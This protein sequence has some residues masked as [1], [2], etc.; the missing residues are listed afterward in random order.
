[1]SQ[2]G[3]IE[4]HGVSFKYRDGAKLF[5]SKSLKIHG[6]EK[7][8]L[9]GFS[10]SGKTTFAHLIMGLY[11]V[12]EG[13]ISIDGQNISEVSMSSLRRNISFI[14]QEPLLFHRSIMENIR[15][16]K[17]EATDEE[18]IDAAIKAHAHDFIIHMPNGYDQQVGEM[19]GKLSGGQ[20]QRIVIARAI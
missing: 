20:K 1:M 15:Y 18:V 2:K 11:D 12:N 14:Q 9:V 19:G 4:F 10:G 7:I 8:G 5:D 17:L 6:G 16:G 13:Y 3:E